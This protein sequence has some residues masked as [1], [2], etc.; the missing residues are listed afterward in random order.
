MKARRGGRDTT[1]G[2]RERDAV[3]E[4]RIQSWSWGRSAARP[5]R[6]SNAIE[7]ELRRE[8]EE[9]R[10]EAAVRKREMEGGSRICDR[11]TFLFISVAI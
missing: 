8:G 11:V 1:R 5:R 7:D 6:R 2:R 9:D 4:R 3:G 10:R